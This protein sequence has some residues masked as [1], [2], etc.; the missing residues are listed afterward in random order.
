[1]PMAHTYNLATLEAE[2][3]RIT[4]WGQLGG[5]GVHEIPSQPTIGQGGMLL[6][7]QQLQE[8]QNR[9][10]MVQASLGKK[11]DPISKI[12]WSHGSSGR[13]PV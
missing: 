11:Q 5:E 1:M 13:V 3:G 4:V 12:G 6:S 2:M 9:R 10:I 7:A 8:A